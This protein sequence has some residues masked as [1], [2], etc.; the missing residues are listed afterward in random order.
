MIFRL[1]TSVSTAYQ[2]IYVMLYVYI[3]LV[4]FYQL[5]DYILP[6]PN[7]AQ[8]IGYVHSDGI[9]QCCTRVLQ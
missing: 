4:Q 3:L 6:D 9:D 8:I 1:S 7:E 2:I 5:A